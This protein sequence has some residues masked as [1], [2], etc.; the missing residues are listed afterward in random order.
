MNI[1]LARRCPPSRRRN[2]SRAEAIAQ[3][4]TIAKFF[5]ETE[6]HSPVS[7]FAENASSAGEQDLHT[8]L[9]SVI[10]DQGPLAHLE[11]I[12]TIAPAGSELAAYAH[13]DGAA[14]VEPL[15][16]QAGLEVRGLADVAVRRLVGEVR[17]VERQRQ[18][19]VDGIVKSRL[20]FASVA[21]FA[22]SQRRDQFPSSGF[23]AYEPSV[24]AKFHVIRRDVAR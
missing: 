2:R 20:N 3:L 1:R 14:I 19:V 21:N 5:S 6:T 13:A 11:A 22:L 16:Q 7:Y 23:S 4:R 10:K 18:M 9:R 15:A 8:W 12:R 17:D 24:R